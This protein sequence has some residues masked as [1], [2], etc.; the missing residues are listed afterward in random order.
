[1]DFLIADLP[2][3][4]TGPGARLRELRKDHPYG[5]SQ[6]TGDYFPEFIPGDYCRKSAA[7]AAKESSSHIEIILKLTQFWT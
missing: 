7:I 3:G 4:D 6:L 1:M 5:G 2:L